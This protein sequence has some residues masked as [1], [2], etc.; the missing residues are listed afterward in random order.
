MAASL[1]PTESLVRAILPGLNFR[2]AA[3]DSKPTLTGHFSVFNT[4]TTIR[5]SWEG[6]FRERVAPG[7]FAKTFKENKNIKV[8][9]QHGRDG[10]L[11]DKPIGRILELRE[12]SDGAYYE[13]E[14][15]DG[16]PPLVM[17]GLRSGEYG[18]SFRFSV[19]QEDFN[20]KP[21]RSDDNPDG[22]PERTIK[23]ARVSEFGPVTWG[24]YPT[25]TAGVRGEEQMVRSLTDQ[26][27]FDG[28][29]QNPDLLR[30]LIETRKSRTVV[31][32]A[33]HAKVTFTSRG[34]V[35]DEEKKEERM[36]LDDLQ[37]L[38]SM[39]QYGTW[40]I[41]AQDEDDDP[42]NTTKMNAIIDSIATLVKIEADEP[43]EIDDDT[44]VDYFYS[45]EKNGW[46]RKTGVTDAEETEPSEATTPVEP[47]PSGATTR[48][49][50]TTTSS[51]LIIP[52]IRA[53]ETTSSGLI[54]P[55]RKDQ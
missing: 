30:E 31:T 38:T 52:T 12:D 28:L 37:L 13:V 39:A 34:V 25:A 7:A 45:A 8:L 44:G 47:E 42:G 14:L 18:A 40:Y 5:S 36:D 23:E 26:F 10:M 21:K 22:L 15:F 6:T 17:E 20:E 2:E 55:M 16:I 53:A 9:F 43:A 54:L 11:G 29:T 41:N 27:Q 4:W 48:T 33:P 50:T 1:R 24:A 3:G 51:G 32:T 46:E 19:M 35:V 49:N